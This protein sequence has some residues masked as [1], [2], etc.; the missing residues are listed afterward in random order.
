MFTNGFTPLS[1]DEISAIEAGLASIRQTMPFMIGLSAKD[2]MRLNP[3][4]TKSTQFVQRV[5][6]SIRQNPGMAPQF[7]DA[8]TLENGYML[9]N[10]LGNILISV[11]NLQRKVADTMLATGSATH[12]SALDFY[13]S[14]QRAA[15]SGIPG[16]Q[17]VVDMLKPHFRKTRRSEIS[18]KSAVADAGSAT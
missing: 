16:A 15:K 12:G 13:N 5:V 18:A 7:I 14:A 11:E 2:R 9:Y 10:Q 3:I 8:N 17:A 4:G 6:E 1:A